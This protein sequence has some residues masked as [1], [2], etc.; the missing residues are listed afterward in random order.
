MRSYCDQLY[1]RSQRSISNLLTLLLI[2][3][4]KNLI[5]TLFQTCTVFV[6]ICVPELLAILILQATLQADQT[7]ENIPNSPS[8]SV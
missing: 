1:H 7:I 5:F 2:N 4:S 3:D 6:I 8:I